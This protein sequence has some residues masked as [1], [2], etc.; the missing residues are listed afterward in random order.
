[1]SKRTHGKGRQAQPS[2]PSRE[3]VIAPARPVDR[4]GRQ[5]AAPQAAPSALSGAEKDA[6]PAHE[7]IAA[8]AYQLWEAQGRP[9]GTDREHWFEAERQLRAEAP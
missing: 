1:M 9:E 7:R 6:G 5:T 8:R 2:P 4:P 3:G